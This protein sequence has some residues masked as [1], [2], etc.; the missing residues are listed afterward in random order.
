LTI[1]YFLDRLEGN[2]LTIELGIHVL[3][4]WVSPTQY[5]VG[6]TANRVVG[7]VRMATLRPGIYRPCSESICPSLN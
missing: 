3:F 5:L 1:D 6:R 7:M 4:V 2:P